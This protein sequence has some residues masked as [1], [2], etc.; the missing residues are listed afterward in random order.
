MATVFANRAWLLKNGVVTSDS[1]TTIARGVATAGITDADWDAAGVQIPCITEISPNVSVNTEQVYCP[2]AGQVGATT[3]SYA[4]TDEPTLDSSTS[5]VASLSEITSLIMQL[6]YGTGNITLGTATQIQAQ[7]PE[8]QGLVRVQHF[9]SANA[10]A[11]VADAIFWTR[12]TLTGLN[13]NRAVSVGQ[14]TFRM[15]ANGTDSPLTV[16][17]LVS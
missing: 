11:K 12:A 6:F 7:S 2:T 5:L 15:F 9:D 13:M 4:L 17:N 10:G 14:I 3:A 16:T 1:A 8:V